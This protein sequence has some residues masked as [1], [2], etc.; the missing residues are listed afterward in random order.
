MKIKEITDRY[1]RDL[2]LVYECE[3]CGHTMTGS[4]YDDRYFHDEV[5]PNKKCP[6]CDKSS[7]D[8]GTKLEKRALKYPE[9]MTV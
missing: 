3:N 9:G 1:R 2:E 5:V 7:V 4:G 8:L 6:V